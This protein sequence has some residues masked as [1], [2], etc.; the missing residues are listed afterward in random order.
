VKRRFTSYP[1]YNFTETKIKMLNWVKQF[2]VFCFL[3][4]HK[5]N[6]SSPSF[7]CVLAAGSSKTLELPAGRAFD[8]LH[9]FKCENDDWLFG[10]LSYDLKNEIE[11]LTSSNIDE[12][13]FPDLFF[14]VPRMLLMLNDVELKIGVV[15]LD[16]D[17]IFNAICSTRKNIELAKIK[18][19]EIKSRFTKPEYLTSIEQLHKH[20]LR[21]DCYEVNFCQEFFAEDAIIDPFN[22]YH[23]LSTISPNPF[24]ALYKVEHRYLLCA[25][26][27]RYL[28][29][30]SNKIYSQ[31]IKGTSKRAWG[32][33]LEDENSK[34]NLFNSVKERSENVMIVD[35]VRNDLSKVCVEGS[36]K[37]EELFGIYSFPQVHQMISTVSGELKMQRAISQTFLKLH[38]QW[39]L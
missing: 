16:A 2:S 31:P 32:N 23:Q 21:G 25:S 39:V 14:F 15:D 5:Y 17:E 6:F 3:D 20:I 26:P 33:L 13:K 8:S 4:N 1:V 10:H 37:V 27:E 30:T 19:Q 9:Q 35:L 22:V 36:V 38:F 34:K 29:K 18:T 11:N 24:S 12:I 28:K 7:E